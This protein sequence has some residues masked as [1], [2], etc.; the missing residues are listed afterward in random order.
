[1]DLFTPSLKTLQAIQQAV[2]PDRQTTLQNRADLADTL[3][4]PADLA[5]ALLRYGGVMRPSD[6]P[7]LGSLDLRRV[8]GAVPP[9]ALNVNGLFGIGQQLLNWGADPTQ[10]ME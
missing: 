2:T 1:V 6:T 7:A 3:G 8:L 10:T 4:A 9:P 5:A